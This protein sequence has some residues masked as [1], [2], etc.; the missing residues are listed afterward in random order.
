M[1]R[2]EGIQWP[3]TSAIS[4]RR[5]LVYVFSH[6]MEVI[7]TTDQLL[8][9]DPVSE[10]YFYAPFELL[11]GGQP[12]PTDC[13]TSTTEGRVSLELREAA[14]LRD[15]NA[16]LN[17]VVVGY[18][19]NFKSTGSHPQYLLTAMTQL[20]VTGSNAFAAWSANPKQDLTTDLIGA[21]MSLAAAAAANQQIMSDFHAT[22]QAVRN[23]GA[24]I[25]ESALRQGLKYP[26]IAVSGEDDPP[27]YPVNVFIAPYPQYHLP[28]TVQG[29]KGPTL[30]TIR[31]IIASGQNQ[32]TAPTVPS[33]PP[34][35]EVILYIHGEGSRAEEAC[36]LIPKLFEAGAAAGRSFTVIAFDLPSNGYSTMIPHL[37]IA[38]M[39]QMSGGLTGWLINTL[40]PPAEP[41]IL[42][43]IEDTIVTFVETLMAPFPNPI[44]AVVGGSLGGHMVLRLAAS[45][46][47]WVRNVV[48]W[49]PASVWDHTVT[50]GGITLSQREL[51]DPHLAGLANDGPTPPWP[52]SKEADNVRSDFF[53]TVFCKDT[54]NSLQYA[55]ET[56]AL[57]GAL[58]SA[59]VIPLP[60]AEL[61]VPYVVGAILAIPTVPP[62][63]SMWYSD[64]WQAKPAAIENDRLDRREVYNADFRRWHWRICAEMIDYTFDTL[65]SSMNK[66][67]LL[68]V[69]EDD[70]YP[71]VHFF[72]N[73][74]YF[75]D[76]L[77]GLGKAWTVEKTGHSIHNERPT[78]LADQIVRFAPRP[79]PGIAFDTGIVPD[80]IGK[81]PA[82]AQNMIEGAYFRYAAVFDPL[83]FVSSPY[84]EDSTPGAGTKAPLN[85]I[86]TVSIA[87]PHKGPVP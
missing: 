55:S 25:N 29:T 24:G 83:P 20:A 36:D 72:P 19:E 74:Q 59:G 62:Q 76:T 80:V 13:T 28:I 10:G 51:S 18:A 81:T 63:P 73:V 54:F 45:Q 78:F 64:A 44:T 56:A 31:Y 66:P 1:A 7:H 30:L 42:K 82:E 50:S 39:P 32:G 4:L 21:G 27:D 12:A 60:I 26:W 86:V 40:P 71:Q 23:P 9:P 53:S 77:P 3:P 87:S 8:E 70:D 57:A 33:I 58:V 85:T 79:V 5:M 69:G 41:P 11:D 15:G 49:S 37:S 6:N 48:A 61:G 75:A 14:R 22:L 2:A 84:V 17:R 67:L 43:F 65:V 34:D 47:A 68:L 38:D 52:T 16:I 35:D 46:K